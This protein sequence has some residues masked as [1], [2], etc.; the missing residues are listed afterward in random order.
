VVEREGALDGRLGLEDLLSE[1]VGC[2]C[3]SSMLSTPVD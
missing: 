1:R 3:L 2:H